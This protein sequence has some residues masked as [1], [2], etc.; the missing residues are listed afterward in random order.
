M[1][2]V[3]CAGAFSQN[4]GLV[5]LFSNQSAPDYRRVEVVDSINE[6]IYEVIESLSNHS[7]PDY[8]RVEVA[9]TIYKVIYDT[10]YISVNQPSVIDSSDLI[11]TPIVG[12]FDRSILNYR[13][14]P[15]GKWLFGMTA[16]Y[17]NYESEDISA[18]SIIGNLD[19][20]AKSYG[21]NPFV[22]YVYKD[23]QFL[24]AKLGYEQLLVSL[25]H[26]DINIMEDLD[27]SLNDFYYSENLYSMALVHR[28]YVG[29]DTRK[30]FGF[31]SETTLSYK[32]GF[33]TLKRGEN[34]LRQTTRTNINEFRLQMSPGL[35]I[36]IMQNVSAELSLGIIG[37]K[38]RSE[39][40][41]NEDGTVEGSHRTSGAD[42]K[43]SLLNIN[44]GITL[45]L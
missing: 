15:K 28:S 36:Y 41:R 13:F 22:G 17:I 29:I 9:D 8:K 25:E 11:K 26:L 20:N 14:L 21:F 16:S 44:F 34:E 40:Q 23:N 32:T 45:C 35:A 5:K 38:F 19:T 1:F 43:I 12:R 30:R 10:V 3:Q 6:V 7:T 24:G 18:F 42:F 4:E 37:M 31:F 39:K 27:F 2:I 33:S